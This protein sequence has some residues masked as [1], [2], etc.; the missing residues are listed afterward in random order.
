MS[1]RRENPLE[2]IEI[3]A[4]SIILHRLMVRGRLALELDL[5]DLEHEVGRELPEVRNHLDTL[6]G[7]PAPML[8]MHIEDPSSPPRRKNELAA[9][10][11][12]QKHPGRP[13][14]GADNGP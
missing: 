8:A 12:N 4:L 1:D 10:R 14:N 9:Q 5:K 7:L 11:T 13:K 2:Q 6:M 3:A